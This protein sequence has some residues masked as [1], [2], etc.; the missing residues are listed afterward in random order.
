MSDA[1]VWM[2]TWLSYLGDA[3]E[4][5]NGADIACNEKGLYTAEFVWTLIVT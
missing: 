5:V 4:E 3:I 1:I 2:N